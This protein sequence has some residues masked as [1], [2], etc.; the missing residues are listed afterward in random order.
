MGAIGDPYIT[1][2]EFRT[3]VGSV[4]DADDAALLDVV[5]PDP[6]NRRMGMACGSAPGT[7]DFICP[8]NTDDF[9]SGDIDLRP[10]VRFLSY[11]ESADFVVD[12]VYLGILT[13]A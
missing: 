1:V 12:E 5:V 11:A 2:A 4:S 9:A 10:T 3:R 7:A 6:S 8:D 13:P